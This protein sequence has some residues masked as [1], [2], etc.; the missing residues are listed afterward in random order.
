[1]RPIS[2]LLLLTSTLIMSSSCSVFGVESVEE[3]PYQS[4]LKEAPFEIR[5]YASF[6]VAQTSIQASRNEAGNKAFRILFDYISG[7]NESNSKISM[8]APVIAKAEANSSEKIAMTAPVLAQQAGEAW[9]Y[10][11]VLPNKYSIDNAPSPLNPKVTLVETEPRR[12][13]TIRYSGRDNEQSRARNT[14]ALMKWIEAEGLVQQSTPRWAGYNPP[15]TLPSQRRNEVL[16]DIAT[17]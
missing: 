10:S 3:A 7:N 14:E 5:D 6:V 11:F 9:V 15:W 8:T 1:M 2:T 16:I 4:V 13:A 12:V 17:Q